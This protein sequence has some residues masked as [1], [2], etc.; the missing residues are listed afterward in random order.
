[1]VFFRFR[2][3]RLL[4]VLVLMLLVVCSWYF[5]FVVLFVFVVS[6][7]DDLGPGNFAS[8]AEVDYEGQ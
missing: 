7:P 1:M 8:V 2:R 4:N 3:C 6:H 5:G